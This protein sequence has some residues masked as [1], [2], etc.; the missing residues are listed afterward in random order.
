MNRFFKFNQ[1]QILSSKEAKGSPVKS[2]F[3][4]L[5]KASLGAI[6]LIAFFSMSIDLHYGGSKDQLSLPEVHIRSL[7]KLFA[8]SASGQEVGW[9]GVRGTAKFIRDFTTSMNTT[10]EEWKNNGL[11]NFSGTYTNT[12]STGQA[13][14]IIG[15]NS[16]SVQGVLGTYNYSYSIEVWNAAGNK[17]YEIFMDNPSNPKNS[18]ILLRY[19]PANAGESGAATNS[20]FE[21]Q[22]NEATTGGQMLCVA[23]SGGTTT[24]YNSSNA[25]WSILMMEVKE[26]DA[27]GAKLDV[28]ILSRLATVDAITDSPCTTNTST[29]YWGIAYIA[30]TAS[31]YKSTAVRGG[32]ENTVASTPKFCGNDTAAGFFNTETYPDSNYKYLAEVSYS[33]QTGYPT[34]ADVK[35]L[36]AKMVSGGGGSVNQ[37]VVDNMATDASGAYQVAFKNPTKDF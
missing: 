9:D 3:A 27:T 14:R 29:D 2:G 25:D 19:S 4:G 23:D 20:M 15:N 13:Y 32:Y 35:A 31:P 6:A 5:K 34:L 22:L 17:I 37:T 33:D 18:G 21:C 24:K 10:M 7:E 16:Q 12:D 36:F 28:S 1:N 11:F 26:Q 8:F 30:E